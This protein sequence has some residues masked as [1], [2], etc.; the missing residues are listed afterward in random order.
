MSYLVLARK[1][2]PQSFEDLVGQGS[3]V[4][5]L[6][7]AIEQSRLAHAYLFSGP[8]G[9]GKTSTA[10]IL[11]K[12]LNCIEGPTPSPCGKCDFC[13][14]I[15]DGSSVDVI[16]IDGASNNSVEDIRDL[17]E[18]VKYAPSGAKYK[19]YIIDET[20]M[21]SQA[22]FNALLKTLEEPPSH[23]V[24]V[25]ATTAPNKV[26]VTVLSRCQHLPFRRIPTETI[27]DR[28]QYIVS[29]ENGIE[30]TDGAIEMLARAADGSMRDALTLLDQV[31]AFSLSVTEDDL[32][33]LLGM[34]DSDLLIKVVEA[35][36]SGDR[37]AILGLSEEIFEGGVEIKDLAGALT[38]LARKMLSC[39][40]TGSVSA[41]K[42]LSGDER[43]RVEA[44]L[45]GT[46]EE[47][48]TLLLESLLRAEGEIRFSAYPRIAMEMCLIKA[49]FLSRFRGISELLGKI[50][51]GSSA[52]SGLPSTRTGKNMKG[53]PPKAKT[54]VKTP[55]ERKASKTAVEDEQVND[56]S[57]LW[58]MIVKKIDEK[59]HP[60]A[61]KLMS[62]DATLQGDTLTLVFNGADSFHA[63]SV[64]ENTAPISDAATE[65]TAR[66]IKV[67][68]ET[69][70]KE[71]KG[72]EDL[73]EM[74]LNDPLVKETIELFDGRVVD[75]RYKR[76]NGN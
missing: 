33:D 2:R 55:T 75:V 46:S 15:A 28:L 34:S 48:I 49:S 68:I 57:D 13:M 26:P 37:E 16:E 72:A 76:Q 40:I 65:I 38:D 58:G 9:V 1:W 69:K 61:S 36:L 73:R 6:Q 14:A 4:R 20:H 41:L 42:E 12:A 47:H 25:L 51:R 3:I 22:A 27:R 50:S 10:R 30:I 39:K 66:K 31:S 64:K 8:R 32:R 59:N 70:K 5:I 45:S 63:G 52:E 17:R 18:K 43:G 62:A 29:N 67:V 24:F 23:V 21:L 19:V 7:N 53:T 11:S 74:I 54:I 35:V 60:L 71:T 56:V 44:I